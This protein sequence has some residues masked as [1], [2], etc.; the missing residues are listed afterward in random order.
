MAWLPCWAQHPGCGV[1]TAGSPWNGSSGAARRWLSQSYRS[2][3]GR[4]GPGAAGWEGQGCRLAGSEFGPMI[5]ARET[6]HAQW[7]G[8][9]GD[10]RSSPG[11][12]WSRAGGRRRGGLAEARLAVADGS[13]SLPCCLSALQQGCLQCCPGWPLAM[14][15][16]LWAWAATAPRAKHG[17][18]TVPLQGWCWGRAHCRT[19]C[20]L[21]HWR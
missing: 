16:C 14:L 10:L 20:R 8:R 21:P 5:E 17:A 12:G 1:A 9:R 13:C 11:R 18:V 4:C 6:L 2:Q 7:V 19:P 3:F 15:R